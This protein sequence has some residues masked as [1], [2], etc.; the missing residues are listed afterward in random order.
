M[1]RASGP[2]ELRP[3][4][5]TEF[6]A[7]I[8]ATSDSGGYGPTRIGAGI[9]GFADLSLGDRVEPVLEALGVF[10]RPQLFRRRD[11]DER[12]RADPETAPLGEEAQTIENAVAEVRLGDGAESRD[13]ARGGDAVDL[14]VR[15]VGRV[16]AAQP[17]Y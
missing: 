5:E 7:G 9:V 8:A 4:G 12:V 13:R 1:Y 3:I 2:E 6:V 10:E 14:V 15:R 16:A 11:A 17:V